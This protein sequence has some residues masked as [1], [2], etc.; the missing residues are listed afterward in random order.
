MAR[1]ALADIILDA[2][3]DGIGAQREQYE[4]CRDCRRSPV[5][6]CLRHEHSY[7]LAIAYEETEAL[8]RAA[9][10]DPEALASIMAALGG[11]GETG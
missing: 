7:A 6:H 1:P 8:F 5:D 4:L 11:E 3:S 10:S 9:A 2:L